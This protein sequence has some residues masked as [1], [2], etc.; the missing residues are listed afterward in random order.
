LPLS[1]R[2]VLLPAPSA[3]LLTAVWLDSRI[4]MP[5]VTVAALVGAATRLT[6]TAPGTFIA[7]PRKPPAKDVFELPKLK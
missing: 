5:D 4:L 3:G 6:E 7:P 2:S 1:R